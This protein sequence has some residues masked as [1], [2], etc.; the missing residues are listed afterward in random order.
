MHANA[1]TRKRENTTRA[2]TVREHARAR[3]TLCA[4]QV[5]AEERVHGTKKVVAH[6][7]P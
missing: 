7:T 6:H 2:Y 5:E 1:K 4:L 3:G